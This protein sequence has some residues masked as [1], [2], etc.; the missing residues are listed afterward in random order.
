MGANVWRSGFRQKL[1]DNSVLDDLAQPG[2]GVAVIFDGLG[3]EFC[4]A[5]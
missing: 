5:C 2:I 3:D 1:R 4:R